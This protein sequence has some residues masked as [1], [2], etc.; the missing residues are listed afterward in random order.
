MDKY[1]P[2][3]IHVDDSDVPIYKN[4]LQGTAAEK[5][6]HFNAL[7][8]LNLLPKSLLTIRVTLLQDATL[9]GFR[10]PHHFC[11]GE[12]TYHVVKAYRDL[13]AGEKIPTLIP[14]PDVDHPLS[15]ILKNDTN[16]TLP[17]GVGLEDV[18]YLDPNENL[19]LGFPAWIRYVGYA[20]GKMV[21]A[22]LG[23]SAKSEEKFIHLPGKLVE[24]WRK[25]CQT[26]LE[27]TMDSK[28]VDVP[29]LSNLDVITAWFLQVS[30]HSFPFKISIFKF[31]LDILPRHNP[32]Q[33]P[34]RPNVQLQ[35]PIRPSQARTQ[36]TLPQEQLLRTAC[37][38]GLTLRLPRIHSRAHRSDNSQNSPAQQASTN[39]EGALGVPGTAYH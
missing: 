23:R 28:R 36:H 9:L 38:L 10:M 22:K 5:V 32:R 11:D 39:H 14:P 3:N 24:R 8:P 13:I 27:Q 20:V 15:E 31:L 17:A 7:R 1:L 18:S 16:I 29:I 4:Q 34:S 6:F 25:E 35:L 33:R 21:G 30:S 2:V 37:P 12:S 26:E 19:L